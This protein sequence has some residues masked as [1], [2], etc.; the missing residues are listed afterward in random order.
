M[1]NSSS[2]DCQQ[3]ASTGSASLNVDFIKEIAKDIS[4]EGR[5]FILPLS[6]MGAM[7]RIVEPLSKMVE[8]GE[9][10]CKKSNLLFFRNSNRVFKADVDFKSRSILTHI[11]EWKR[12][13]ERFAYFDG[14]LWL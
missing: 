7:Q 3:T 9:F 14:L 1:S 12:L 4:K 2:Q 11:E 6:D 10:L 8:E 13:L 5:V